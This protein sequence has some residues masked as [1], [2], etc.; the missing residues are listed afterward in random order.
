MEK[1]MTDDNNPMCSY[2]AYYVLVNPVE[3]ECH[4]YP[5]VALTQ[6]MGPLDR[7]TQTSVA[8]PVIQD[9]DKMWCG[10]Y[11]EKKK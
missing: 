9:V 1:E 5:P 10:E 8:W 4:R 3:G 6:P 11:K 7:P 2:C